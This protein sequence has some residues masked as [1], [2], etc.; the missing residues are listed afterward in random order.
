MKLCMQGTYTIGGLFERSPFVCRFLRNE[1]HPNLRSFLHSV[2]YSLIYLK[3]LDKTRDR[4][5][6]APLAVHHHSTFTSVGSSPPRPPRTSGMR[7]RSKSS[8]SHKKGYKT[9]LVVAAVL[10]DASTN[11]VLLAQRPEGKSMAGLWEYP[12]GK[13][14]EGEIP[15]KALQRELKEELDIDVT[16][17]SLK[18]LTFASHTYEEQMTHLLMPLYTCRAWMGVPRG[19]EGQ[20]LAWASIE[21][22][23]TNRFEMPAADGPLLDFVLGELKS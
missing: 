10:I 1:H 12:G 7:S 16:L 9:L 6:I 17:E 8:Q 21:D 11:K 19:M 4:R 22:L 2:D 23:Q 14:D 18:P 15:E 3:D 13:V 20:A 5:S